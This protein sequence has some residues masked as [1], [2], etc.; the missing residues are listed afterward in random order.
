MKKVTDSS[1]ECASQSCTANTSLTLTWQQYQ[2]IF[3][4]M[5]KLQLLEILTYIF[6]IFGVRSYLLKITEDTKQTYCLQLL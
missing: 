5:M 4:H 6:L 3:R 2:S 1:S